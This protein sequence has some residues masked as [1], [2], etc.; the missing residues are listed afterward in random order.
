[1]GKVDLSQATWQLFR[2]L[3]DLL[4]GNDFS[5]HLFDLG[6]TISHSV[7]APSGSIKERPTYS[8]S[9]ILQSQS[10]VLHLTIG[11]FVFKGVSGNI[12]RN[13]WSKT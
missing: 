9:L 10:Q 6:S 5:S 1:M 2:T 11:I 4:V 3:G 13:E 8:M 12:Q 7:R